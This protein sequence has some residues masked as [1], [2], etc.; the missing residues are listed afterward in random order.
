MQCQEFESVIEQ[1]SG[2][3]LPADAA[4]HSAQCGHCRALV[5]DL[6]T[7]T[8]VARELA[9]PVEDAPARIWVQLRAQLETEGIIR[10]QAPEKDSRLQDRGGFAGVLAWMR[11]PAMIATYAAVMV[12]AAAVAWETFGPEPPPANIPTASTYGLDRLE[13]QTVSDLESASPEVNAVLRKDLEVVNKFIVEC[14]KAVREEPQNQD[15]RQYL[16]GAYQQKAEL[17]AVAMDRTRTGE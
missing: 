1:T 13:T 14:E 6:Q 11:R 15:A 8:R 16:Y 9:E 17:L 7:I 2:Q 3:P 5:A 4:N 12:L 10:A